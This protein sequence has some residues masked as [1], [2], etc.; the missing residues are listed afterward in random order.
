[1]NS[2]DTVNGIIQKTQDDSASRDFE[3]ARINIMETI[4]VARE[5]AQKLA[6][7]ADSSQHPRAFE[8]LAKLIDSTVAAN[9]SLLD[10]QSKIREMGEIS[11]P[12]NGSSKTINNNL[13]VGTTAELGEILKKIKNEN[14]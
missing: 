11:S 4:E 8:V 6:L 3:Y 1:M 13:F 5:S 9:K 14:G 10:L 2:D 7:I 12:V